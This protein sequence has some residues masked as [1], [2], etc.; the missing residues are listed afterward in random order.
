MV[1]FDN[2]VYFNATQFVPEVAAAACD[3]FLQKYAQKLILGIKIFGFLVVSVL[4]L[5]SIIQRLYDLMKSIYLIAHTTVFVLSA[6]LCVAITLF[7]F[8]NEDLETL[9]IQLIW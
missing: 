6:L 9:G 8:T 3:M 2:A 4:V 1:F 5:F 7:M